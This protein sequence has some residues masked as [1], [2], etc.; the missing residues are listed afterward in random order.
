[1]HI[2]GNEVRFWI[3]DKD[4]DDSPEWGDPE[5]TTAPFSISDAIRVS[6]LELRR[7]GVDRP[8]T[9]HVSQVTIHRFQERPRWFY[10]VEWR[11]RER[12]V[13]DGVSIPVLMNGRVV[14]GEIKRETKGDKGT[15]RD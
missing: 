13:G 5:S 8:E 7:Y 9:W 6:K 4:L 12:Q 3:W 10:V 2:L 14:I 11:P 1:M 15:A